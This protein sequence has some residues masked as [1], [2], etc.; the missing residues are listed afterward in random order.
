MNTNIFVATKLSYY[1]RLLNV[2][3]FGQSLLYSYNVCQQGWNSL[4]DIYGAIQ[5]IA[6][7]HVVIGHASIDYT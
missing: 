1:F 6:I 2:T 7:V 3:P 5:N 4:H